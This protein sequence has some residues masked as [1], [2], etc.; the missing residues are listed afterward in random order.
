MSMTK[1]VINGIHMTAAEFLATR[2]A[3]HLPQ[4]FLAD[5]LGIG[6]ET[7]SRWERGQYPIPL[8]AVTA[9]RDQVSYRREI[10]ARLVAEHSADSPAIFIASLGDGEAEANGYPASW[11]RGVA[12]EAQRYMDLRI[13]HEPLAAELGLETSESNTPNVARCDIYGYSK[14]C[15]ENK[16]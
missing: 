15:Q 13:V 10:V 14:K 3:L 2:E 4:Q 6:R 12:Y 8:Y 16:S 9:M 5:K 7:I 1:D 11:W